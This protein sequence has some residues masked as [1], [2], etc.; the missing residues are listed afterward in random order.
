MPPSR[1]GRDRAAWA[2]HLI[3]G[4][5][6]VDYDA[7]LND[8]EG[9]V[10]L[11][12]ERAGMSATLVGQA[13]RRR[14][15]ECWW[16][17]HGRWVSTLACGL[18]L[19][20]GVGIAWLGTWAGMSRA[21]QPE[22]CPG[23]L[24]PGRVPRGGL[25][26][27]PGPA[28]PAAVAARHRRPDGAGDPGGDRPGPVGRGGDGRLPVR[29][30]RGARVAE[31]GPRPP[32]RPQAAGDRARRP[33][34]GSSRTGRAASVPAGEVRRGRPRPGPR[35]RHGSRSTGRWSR[36]GR[37]STRRRSP[38]SRSRSSASRATRSSPGT[39]NGEGALEVEAS[40][41]VGDALISR[42]VAQVREAQAGRAPVER[43]IERFAAVLHARSWW[44]SRCWSCSVPPLLAWAGSAAAAG[45][46]VWHD[47]FCKGLVVLVIACPCALVIATPV[48]VVSGLAAAARRGRPD[49]G[50]RVPRGVRP[51]PRPGLRQDGDPD[52]AASP[53]WSR[54]SAPPGEDDER[55]VLRIAAALGDR[56]GHVLGRAIAR[57]ARDLRLDVPVADDYR[58]VPGLGALGAGRRGRVSHR[59]PPLHR[60]G[61]PLP[62]RRSTPSSAEAEEA[63]GTSVALT[64]ASGPL[65]WIRL[66]DRPRP[67][68]AARPGRAAR[69]G[70]GPSC[71]PA[72]TPAPP[73]PWPGSWASASSAPACC[74]PTRSRRSPT[75]TLAH[76]PTGM[77]G[78]GV[79]DAPALAAARV[80]VALGGHLQRRRAR[81]RRHRPDGRRPRPPPLAGPPQ[82][83]HPGP[84]PPEHRPGRCSPRPSSWSWPSSAWPTSG[85]PSPPTS[86]PACS[87]SPTPCGCSADPPVETV[88]QN[89][90]PPRS[91]SFS[92]VCRA[93][94]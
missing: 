75:S 70:L 3:H 11:V 64:A 67:E 37:A 45:W 19:A 12:H 41:P 38:A 39:V 22:T 76:G 71:S 26:L 78:D 1:S 61:G 56:G 66:A 73:P 40:G 62:A 43:R 27:S 13:R 63:V 80:S 44:P 72:T 6:T 49:Q 91:A 77:V 54:S 74:P 9:L 47:W 58:A 30:V 79:N 92:Q 90:K 28:E 23:Q 59:Q 32:R 25:A 17:H 4:L 93:C 15:G 35:R 88:N 8:P 20:A 52:A 86:A 18:A 69:L 65:G 36:G 42:I 29:A 7:G 68:A 60:R 34:S 14:A 21:D 16:S 87:S 53:T 83:R 89:P 33:P 48:A 57:H 94:P 10:R 51:A 84:D 2:S 81:D 24:C 46:P 55:P 5:M 31:P 50:G 85:W 82:P